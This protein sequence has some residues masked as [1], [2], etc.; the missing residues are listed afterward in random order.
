MEDEIDKLS[1][2]S[3]SAEKIPEE[4]KIPVE[5]EI[6]EKEVKITEIQN[7]IAM[8]CSVTDENKDKP[9]VMLSDFS[10]PKL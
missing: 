1:S 10:V 9:W 8:D 4:L 6:P 7:I 3:S 2:R 5:L